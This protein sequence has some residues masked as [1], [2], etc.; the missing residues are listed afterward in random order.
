MTMILEVRA[1]DVMPA[2]AAADPTAH[3]SDGEHQKSF[4]PLRVALIDE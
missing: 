3:Q 1:K 4:V 2:V